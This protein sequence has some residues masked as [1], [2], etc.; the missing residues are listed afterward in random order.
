MT[1]GDQCRLSKL[2]LVIYN[3]V[4]SLL[5]LSKGPKDPKGEVLAQICEK[6][7]SHVCIILV[8]EKTKCLVRQTCNKNWHATAHDNK[9][10]RGSKFFHQKCLGLMKCQST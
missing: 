5:N 6:Y 4:I 10:F 8:L 7:S 9:S 2:N 1:P 3:R